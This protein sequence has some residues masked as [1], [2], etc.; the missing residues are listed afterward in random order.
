MQHTF[1]V[2]DHTGDTATTF[3]PAS[4]VSVADAEK[5]F[6]ELTGKGFTAFT[7]TEKQGEHRI[8]KSFDPTVE[9][10]VFFPALQGG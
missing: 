2:M 8:V 4:K 7:Q 3:D 9:E 10:T 6:K 1:R 5:R